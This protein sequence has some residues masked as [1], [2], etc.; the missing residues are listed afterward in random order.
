ML[1]F[2]NK[3][4]LGE[5]LLITIEN[6]DKVFY[7]FNKNITLIR[8][9]DNVL[10]G[11]NIFN[12]ENLNIAGNGVVELSSEQKNLINTRLE[13]SEIK[14]D[15]DGNNKDNFVVGEVLTKEKHPDADKLSI[16]T[17][18]I[19]EEEILQIVCGASN[20]AAGQKVIVAKIGAM[21]PSGLLIRKS[22]LRGV[23]SNGMLCSR[24]ELGLVNDEIKGILVLEEDAVVGTKLTDLNLK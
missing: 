5:T 22:K 15:L 4:M 20:V 23:E 24:K 2:Y 16:T 14:I 1:F 9:E 21:M 19:S 7:E 8:N 3:E 18:K 17:V 6:C 13:K 11:I 10:V 12:V